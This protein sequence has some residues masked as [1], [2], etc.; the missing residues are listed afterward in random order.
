MRRL[1]TTLILLLLQLV[2]TTPVLAAEGQMMWAVH[3]SVAPA[4]CD[5]S[6]TPGIV[7]AVMV[8]YALHDAVAKPLPGNPTAPSLAESWT[9]SSDGVTYDVTLRSGVKFHNGAPVTADD[10]K[11]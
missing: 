2:T 9:V 6:E 10:V 8:P 4:W 5:P 1:F 3:I 11:F 7:T